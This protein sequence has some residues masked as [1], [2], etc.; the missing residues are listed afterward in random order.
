M[1]SIYAMLAP[2]VLVLSGVFHLWAWHIRQKGF[3]HDQEEIRSQIL[4]YRRQQK[5][6]WWKPIAYAR[7]NNL[8]I[9]L[10]PSTRA[11]TKA[12]QNYA[13][14]SKAM[15][16]EASGWSTLIIGTVIIA[17]LAITS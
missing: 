7:S 6:H 15:S 12:L 14:Q 5:I 9:V 13:L 2:V 1:D 10:T 11:E 16:W 8:A 3:F 17:I 4:E